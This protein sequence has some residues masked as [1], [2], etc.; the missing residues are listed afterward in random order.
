MLCRSL[1]SEKLCL[2]SIHFS[3]ECELFSGLAGRNSRTLRL[4]HSLGFGLNDCLLLRS[5]SGSGKGSGERGNLSHSGVQITGLGNA[6]L[7]R[8]NDCLLLLFNNNLL[9][10]RSLSSEKLCIESIHF[11]LECELFSCQICGLNRCR[12]QHSSLFGLNDIFLLFYTGS[13]KESGIE[14]G[15]LCLCLC[16]G[17]IRLGNTFL[18]CL[19]D[20]L[21]FSLDDSLL[22]FNG[23]CFHH[24]CIQSIHF[25]L[26][27]ELLLGL[28]SSYRVRSEH[29]MLFCLND[30]LLLSRCLCCEESSVE[31]DNLSHDTVIIVGFADT[32]ALSLNDGL[33][34]CFNNNGLFFVCLC[35]LHCVLESFHFGLKTQL[36]LGLLY[37]ELLGS[38]HLTCFSFNESLLLL[39]GACLQKGSGEGGDFR[40]SIGRI[41]TLG[42]TLL[43]SLNDSLLFSFDNGSSFFIGLGSLHCFF[44]SLHFCLKLHLSIGRSIYLLLG[45][46]HCLLFAV[47]NRLLFFCRLSREKGIVECDNFCSDMIKTVGFEN[48]LLLCLDD[49]LLLLFCNDL[50]MSFGGSS[51]HFSIETVHL[52][53]KLFLCFGFNGSGFASLEHCLLFGNDNGLL[54]LGGSCGVKDGVEH[55]DFGCEFVVAS[56][57]LGNALFLRF[58][59]ALLLLFNNCSL[60]FGSFCSGISSVELSHFAFKF[61]LFYRFFSGSSRLYLRLG[62]RL[63]LG[64]DNCLFLLRSRSSCK[65][66]GESGNFSH[67][68]RDITGLGSTLLFGFDNSLLL[69]FG[70]DLLLSR[71]FSG[72]KFRIQRFHLSLESELFSGFSGGSSIR[73]SLGLRLRHRSGFGLDDRLFLLRS[74]SGCEGS[75]ESCN[76]SHGGRGITGFGSTLLLGFDNGLL[77]FFGND[78]LL[79]RCLSGEKFRIQ[80]FHLS[81]ESEL[82]SGFSGGS[83]IRLSLG[84]RLRHRSG[85]GLDDRLFLLRSRSGCEGSGESC[86]F[87]HGGRGITGFGSTLLLGFDNGL[88]LFFGN[89]LLLSRC[90][91]GEKFRIQGFHFSLEST[92]F[93]RFLCC[94]SGRT[95]FNRLGHCLLFSSDNSLLFIGRV[96]GYEC[97]IEC[98]NFRGDCVISFC[99]LRNAL[100]FSFHN[101]SLL[102]L[103][104][105]F[106]LLG[107]LS[108]CIS[109]VEL[110]HFGFE[111]LLFCGLYSLRSFCLGSFLRSLCHSLLLGNDNS[112]LFFRCMCCCKSG[113]ECGDLGINRIELRVLGKAFLLCLYNSLLLLLDNSLLL[114]G[115]LCSN[116]SIV[117]TVHLGLELLLFYCLYSRLSGSGTDHCLFF[118]TDNGIFRLRCLSCNVS[119]VECR[120]FRCELFFVRIVAFY[121]AALFLLCLDDCLLL[122]LNNSVLGCRGFSSFEFAAKRIHLGLQFLL[123]LGQ[124]GSLGFCLEHSLL[125]GLDDSVFFSGGLSRNKGSVETLDLVCYRVRI[126]CLGNAMLLCVDNCLLLNIE[127]SFLFVLGLC[128]LQ[129]GIERIHIR[130]ELHLLLGLDCS[131]HRLEHSNLFGFDDCLLFCRSSCREHCAI[132]LVDFGIDQA[133]ISEVRCQKLSFSIDDCL[134]LFGRSSAG[135]GSG[136]GINFVI[137]FCL[138]LLRSESTSSLSIIQIVCRSGSRKSLLLCCDFCLLF[139]LELSTNLSLGKSILQ[140]FFLFGSLSGIQCHIE[141]H[142][143]CLE[144]CHLFG[145]LVCLFL[146]LCSLFVSLLLFSGAHLHLLDTLLGIDIRFAFVGV[147]NFLCFSGSLTVKYG[148]FVSIK[149]EMALICICICNIGL[150]IDIHS[151]VCVG[152]SFLITVHQHVLNTADDVGG[153]VDQVCNDLYGGKLFRRHGD[154]IHLALGG[155]GQ[156]A[157]GNYADTCSAATAKVFL[158]ALIS[159]FCGQIQTTGG[160]TH[161]KLG[162]RNN[163][164]TA[165]GNNLLTYDGVRINN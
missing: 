126:L 82:F 70:N 17:V 57:C 164:H 75:G 72:E 76:F 123:I 94:L 41:E 39:K 61:L 29:S 153:V 132:E 3:L 106:L 161:R 140:I 103:Y 65:G 51:H 77:L 99:T 79:S 2:E 144:S 141:S 150:N 15:N 146:Q 69:F 108:S 9:L 95:Y 42:N 38:N 83:S 71:R 101:S 28:F 122:F 145:T 59:N 14:C 152:G 137:Q 20:C 124:N 18:L 40:H 87:S 118:G 115:S 36:L 6:F 44:Q 22:F 160:N 47:D 112:L 16:N 25:R 121:A 110:I 163:H 35:S 155:D 138:T 131:L 147:Q 23:S 158:S 156:K 119:C 10:C 63:S 46:Q 149:N 43:L 104:N 91:S 120:N 157:N 162:N 48:A 33:F 34:L 67:S 60:L 19:N 127:N 113:I 26:K 159:K 114:F 136:K 134:L 21:F 125:F 107:R 62:H 84:L 52:S 93:Y 116:K 97:G 129:C 7:L 151:H 139:A 24:G 8:L 74:R 55:S 56:A 102:F 12:L 81:L 130:L 31:F 4:D 89:D 92:L 66:S 105:G 58:N 13:S 30:S 50:L 53:F 148:T 86:N 143:F 128:S 5:G 11:S 78:L 111:L 154:H 1:S 27:C 32:S 135:E 37:G 54:F 90:L 142:N 109:G 80:R 98:R 68:G 45:L 165:R 117:E 133:G 85:F 88:L 64:L 73:L 96:C 49:R 100:L